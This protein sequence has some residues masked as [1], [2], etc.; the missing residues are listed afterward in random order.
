MSTNTARGIGGLL[1]PK[2]VAEIWTEERR[3]QEP[4]AP[5][6]DVVTVH[7]YLRFS[8]PT[9]PGVKFRNR[10][11]D[12]PMP[13]PEA[14]IGPKQPAWKVEQEGALRDW[15]HSRKGQGAKGHRKP[16]KAKP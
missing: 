6:V 15:W 7:N 4:E 3:K 8:K 16:R 14:R 10:Y 1:F 9:P 12:N 2:H 5:A 13:E 11:E